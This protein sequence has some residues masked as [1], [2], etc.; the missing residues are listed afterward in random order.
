MKLF[1]NDIPVIVCT[2]KNLNNLTWYATIIN[3]NEQHISDLDIRLLDDVLI[4]SAS[5]EMVKDLFELM[6]DKKLKMVDSV[7]IEVKD[8]KEVKKHIKSVFNIVKAAGGVVEKN[9]KILLIHRLGKWDLPKGKLEKGESKRS[10]AVR[11][12]EEETGVKVVLDD[13]ICSTW[14]T[15]TR[16]RKYVLKKTYWYRMQCLNDQQMSPQE[17]EG[18]EDVQWMDTDGVRKALYDSYRT[19]R[20][21]VQEYN[22]VS[23]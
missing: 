16:N 12:V 17:E 9:D 7:T 1:I 6:T 3:G 10:G 18:I 11:E 19:I 8:V 22:K 23:E 13:K 14:H 15:Y 20:Y 5:K 4:R 2:T 21:V